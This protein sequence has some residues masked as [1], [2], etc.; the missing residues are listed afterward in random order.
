MAPWGEGEAL[1]QA[2]ACRGR[3]PL[4]F[5]CVMTRHTRCVVTSPSRRFLQPGG[6]SAYAIRA[7]P[8]EKPRLPKEDG[9]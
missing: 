1:W 5:S 8:E 7:L 6:P 3:C 2:P 4:E 9:A